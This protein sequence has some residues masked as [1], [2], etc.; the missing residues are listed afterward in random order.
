MVAKR[1]RPRKRARNDKGHFIKDDPST[2]ENEAFLK[3]KKSLWDIVLWLKGTAK[4]KSYFSW[5][6]GR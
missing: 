5:L 1:G 3:T 4:R 6:T 2:P